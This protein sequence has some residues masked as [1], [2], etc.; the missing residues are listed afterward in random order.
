MEKWKIKAKSFYVLEKIPFGDKVY[1]FIQRYI[2]KSL[3]QTIPGFKRGFSSKV[4]FTFEK[5]EKYGNTP[6]EEAKFYE[7]GAGWNLLSPIG[8]A[9]CIGESAKHGFSYICIDLNEFMHKREVF[10]TM[11]FCRKNSEWIKDNVHSIKGKKHEYTPIKEE[12][13]IGRGGV[14]DYLR[15]LGIEYKAP[16]DARRTGFDSESFD[17]IISNTTM[18][19]IPA[20]DLQSILSECY[21]II[22]TGGL[23]CVT[24][25][26]IDHYTNFDNSISIYNFLKYDSKEWEKFC[27]NFHYQN[28]LRHSDY[29]KLFEKTGFFILEETVTQAS[30]EEYKLLESI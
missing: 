14:Q 7:F 27:P 2:T 13:V 1:Y 10:D 19:L 18:E 16:C 15:R 21:R 11:E 30:K 8:L 12:T 24:I 29:K 26:Y 28:R 23:M 9:Y 20:K 6:I 25:N 17:Y 4:L 22:K 3:N 5:I